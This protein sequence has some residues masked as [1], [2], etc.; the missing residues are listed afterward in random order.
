MLLLNDKVAIVTGASSGIGRETAKLFAHQGAKI[1][2]AA[3]RK[4]LLDSL[5]AELKA[6]GSEAIAIVGDV[7]EESFAEELVNTAIQL[8]GR[9]DIAFNNAGTL[10][11]SCDT[12]DLSIKD[13]DRVIQTN[14][15]ACF[16]GAKHQLRAMTKQ[17]SGS[18]IMTSSFVGFS[19]GL[20]QTAAYSASKAGL[21][22]L[23]RSL[24][25]E[26]GPLGIRIN[27]LL[28]GGTDT[29]MAD[30][31]ASDP[32]VLNAVKS[33][34]ALKRLATAAEIAQSALYLASDQSSF[35]TGSTLLCDGG[36]SITKG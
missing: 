15:S 13:W 11:P 5:A 7:K 23:T 30:S 9:L 3:R 2:I 31:F 10:G 17:H 19:S 29:A 34:H 27:A 35:T 24:A 25:T 22:G 16:L 20:G 12:R 14:L 4:E 18:I 26:F 8:F 21:I 1:I 33:F 6:G 28:P 32:D 36:A